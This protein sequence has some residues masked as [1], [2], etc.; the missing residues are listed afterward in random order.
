MQ[1][2]TRIPAINPVRFIPGND[3]L[4]ASYNRWP[5]DRGFFYEQ[6]R[7]YQT[8]LDYEQKFNDGDR[9]T[10]YFDTLA[11]EGVIIHVL[12]DK[13]VEVTSLGSNIAP[14]TADYILAGNV[15]T[16]SAG[17]D[18]PYLT[19]SKSFTPNSLSV[20]GG[21]KQ[22]FYYLV[23]EC[24]YIAAGDADS[25]YYVSEPIFI[26]KNGWKDTVLIEYT[27]SVNAFDV[28]FEQLFPLFRMRIEGDVVDDDMASHDTVFEDQQYQVRNLQSVPY[29]LYNLIIG[30]AAGVPAYMRDK[31]NRALSCNRF[32]ID[33]TRYSKDAS[34]KWKVA[35]AGD[36]YPMKAASIQL[37]E[38]KLDGGTEYA[39]GGTFDMFQIPTDFGGGIIYPFAISDIFLESDVVFPLRPT[40][41]VIE[42]AAGLTAFLAYLN[43]SFSDDNDLVGLFAVENRG[44]TSFLTYTNGINE[45]YFSSSSD[46]G[47]YKMYA[48]YAHVEMEVTTSGPN[49]DLPI[50]LGTDLAMAKAIIDWGDGIV[51]MKRVTGTA[52]ITHVY[53][54]SAGI[55]THRLRIFH[56]GADVST[57]TA[58]KFMRFDAPTSP[59]YHAQITHVYSTTD[60]HQVPLGLLEFKITGHNIPADS[61]RFIKFAA[62]SLQSLVIAG[63]GCTG[64]G[65]LFTDATLPTYSSLIFFKISN[66][67]LSVSTLN[68]LIND[69]YS[70]T[71]AE[72]WRAPGVFDCRMSPTAAPSGTAASVLALLVSSYG[73]TVLHD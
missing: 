63:C 67:A 33:G 7:H 36:N 72:P 43:G 59:G 13:G 5:F 30:G 26:R 23:I 39:S 3:S 35:G 66:N 14:L 4:P 47:I 27:N 61:W 6:I 37:R 2:A 17:T 29:R 9:I 50:T 62:A 56:C 19:F 1:K 16:D 44:F 46:L 48:W 55:H 69:F 42:D 15:F 57:L 25:V 45:Y 58:I 70:P 41:K 11:T 38:Y 18:Y 32:R 53:A 60:Y 68:A 12:D 34:A 20:L 22:G 28:L 8:K 64:I 71:G 21:K 73:W 31:A 54:D 51:E 65:A 40:P 10:V 49:N 24:I 52:T